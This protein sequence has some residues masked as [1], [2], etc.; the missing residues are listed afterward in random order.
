MVKKIYE[1]SGWGSAVFYNKLA[2]GSYD[3]NVYPQ[4]AG[5]LDKK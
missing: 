2:D 5:G 1:N 4:K 3:I